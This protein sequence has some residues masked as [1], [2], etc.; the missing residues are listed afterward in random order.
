MLQCCLSWDDV[1]PPPWEV[2]Q[3]DHY[4][5]YQSGPATAHDTEP[6][7]HPQTPGS[8]RASRDCSRGVFL[9]QLLFHR[10]EVLLPSHRLL[11]SAQSTQHAK[12]FRE[13]SAF[14]EMLTSDSL[15]HF[16]AVLAP[17]EKSW[18][19]SKSEKL[20]AMRFKTVGFAKG[21]PRS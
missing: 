12:Y 20:Q 16:G 4:Q 7:P 15:A 13:S 11:I 3:I 21:A 1:Q 19:D 2:D 18:A 14:Q 5:H 8:L 9:P 10:N 6:T 17:H